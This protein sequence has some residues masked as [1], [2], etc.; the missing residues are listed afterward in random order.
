MAKL[1]SSRAPTV[2]FIHVK[3]IHLGFKRPSPARVNRNG[4]RGGPREGEGSSAFSSAGCGHPGALTH[5]G[6]THADV[7]AG[8]GHVAAVVEVILDRAPRIE[9]LRRHRRLFA[10]LTPLPGSAAPRRAP[11]RAAERLDGGSLLPAA[12]VGRRCIR[13]SR[14]RRAVAVVSPSEGRIV[15]A[16][17][18]Q[19]NS[20]V[21][22][23]RAFG[24]LCA[25]ALPPI[26]YINASRRVEFY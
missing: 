5:P 8:R 6:P 9:L 25:L 14:L 12:A 19:P 2:T 23:R 24:R 7:D 15:P 3:A 1:L 10:A 16:L 21:P 22:H 11:S 20:T 17:P 26:A 13:Q 4:G 18:E